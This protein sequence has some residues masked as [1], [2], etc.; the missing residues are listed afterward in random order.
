MMLR[1][2]SN[3]LATATSHTQSNCF[4]HMSNGSKVGGKKET[5][6][7]ERF[8][9]VAV[10]LSPSPTPDQTTQLSTTMPCQAGGQKRTR[11]PKSSAPS[12]PGDV[13]GL[14][15]TELGFSDRNTTW[16]TYRFFSLSLPWTGDDYSLGLPA[17]RMLLCLV[18]DRRLLQL[19]D[20]RTSKRGRIPG[21]LRLSWG[22][23]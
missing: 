13:S 10:Y 23:S 19:P 15:L 22:H 7:Q 5:C 12:S 18:P 8:E 6:H 17:G 20:V 1:R 11:Q 2:R 21:L 3:S 14:H 16:A 9:P 4:G